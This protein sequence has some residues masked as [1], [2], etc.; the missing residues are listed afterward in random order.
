[1]SEQELAE[2]CAQLMFERDPAS[3]QA[4]M[5]IDA[6]EQ[7]KEQ[8]SAGDRVKHLVRIGAH[9][10]ALPRGKDDNGETALVAHRRVQWHGAFASASVLA[11]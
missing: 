8:R 5:R 3:Q 4:G 2:R 10:G 1:M 9:A 7:M 6:V 11:K